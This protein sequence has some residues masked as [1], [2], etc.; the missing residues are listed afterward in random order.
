[1]CRLRAAGS[2]E[3]EC[4]QNGTPENESHIHTQ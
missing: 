4:H 3:K 2:T 1:L